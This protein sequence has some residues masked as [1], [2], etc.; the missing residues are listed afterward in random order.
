M[1]PR[2]PRSPR[3]DTLFPYTTLFRTFRPLAFDALDR[4]VAARLDAIDLDA[5]LVGEAGIERVVGLVVARR[6]EIQDLLGL[7]R[8]AAG[9]NSDSGGSNGG[10]QGRAPA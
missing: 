7:G 4:L 9:Q 6:V 3:T 5:R 1:L 2:P 10:T 8:Q